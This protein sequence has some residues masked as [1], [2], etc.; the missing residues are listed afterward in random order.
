VGADGRHRHHRHDQTDPL[1]WKKHPDRQC[2]QR[3]RRFLERA[4][5]EQILVASEPVKE[6]GRAP[7]EAEVNGG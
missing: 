6:S 1:I 5:D 2:E 3:R 7:T 4:R